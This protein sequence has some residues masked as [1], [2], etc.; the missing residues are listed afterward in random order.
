MSHPCCGQ[1]LDT[2]PAS[3]DV[4]DQAGRVAWSPALKRRSPVSSRW[5]PLRVSSTSKFR[6]IRCLVRSGHCGT[7][8]PCATDTGA[9]HQPGVMKVLD[10]ARRPQHAPWRLRRVPEFLQIFSCRPGHS[11]PMFNSRCRRP[12]CRAG[13]NQMTLVA[14]PGHAR[15]ARGESTSRRDHPPRWNSAGSHGGTR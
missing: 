8:I 7:T 9:G 5:P 12:T 14:H 11:L 10:S 1:R 4:S 13:A 15:R 3:R 2:A 6:S